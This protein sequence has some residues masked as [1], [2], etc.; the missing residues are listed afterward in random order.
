MRYALVSSRLG[1]VF[2]CVGLQSY[3]EF[4]VRQDFD[5]GEILNKTSSLKGVLEPFS[6]EGNV[7]LMPRAGFTDIT[8]FMKYVCFEGFVAIK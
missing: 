1:K 8:T 3:N 5:A 6:R 2:Q 7:G 4:K